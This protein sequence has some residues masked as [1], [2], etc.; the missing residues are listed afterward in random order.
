MLETVAICR[1][2]QPPRGEIASARPREACGDQPKF[3]ENFWVSPAGCTRPVQACAKRYANQVGRELARETERGGERGRCRRCRRNA[4]RSPTQS[5][6]SVGSV[7][8]RQP[9]AAAR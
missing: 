8:R 9:I 7:A 5:K 1:L 4:T 2:I 3:L 6:R